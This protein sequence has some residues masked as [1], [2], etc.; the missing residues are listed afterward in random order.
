MPRI[1]GSRVRQILEEARQPLTDAEAVLEVRRKEALATQ[2][3][4]DTQ[5]TVVIALGIA[6]TALEKSLAPQPRQSS[7][8]PATKSAGKPAKKAGKKRG[9]AASESIIAGMLHSAT[10]T[11]DNDPNA[12]CQRDIPSYGLCDEPADANVHHLR[13][14]TGYHEFDAGKSNAPSAAE[15]SSVSN[16][17]ANGTASSET[18]LADVSHAAHAA[19]EGA[20]GD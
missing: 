20:S 17:A 8:K 7:S 1:R 18:P 19:S 4:Y 14:V 16:G 15:R 6:Y 9:A 3:A 5:Q 11:S 10:V 12:R 2:V 13:G